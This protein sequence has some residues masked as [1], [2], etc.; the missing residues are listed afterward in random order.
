M[1]SNKKGFTTLM[2]M[3]FI[4]VGFVLLIVLGVVVYGFDMVESTFSLL[5]FSLGNVSFNETYNATLRPGIT[6]MRTTV[7]VLISTVVLLG[8][9]LVMMI[10]GYSMRKIDKLWILLD[11]ALVIVAEILAVSI[12][13]SFT[14][15][16]NS[17]PEM[18]AIFSNTLSAGSRY[19]LNL[20]III[21]IVGALVML[22]TYLST[23]KKEE[24]EPAP[25]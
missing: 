9:V 16:I 1:D 5:D 19:I 18:L 11:I 13:S 23:T 3:V 20:P 12:S 8:M 4:F 10:V 24:K 25:F 7:P 22:T 21:P 15:F 17:S 6:A 14:T 2:L